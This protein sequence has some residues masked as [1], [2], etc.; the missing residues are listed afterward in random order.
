MKDR[1]TERSLGPYSN[2]DF[3]PSPRKDSDVTNAAVST[4][5]RVKDSELGY[6][7]VVTPA[8]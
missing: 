2:L 1:L 4:P 5:G 7:T 8:R 6:E 3:I